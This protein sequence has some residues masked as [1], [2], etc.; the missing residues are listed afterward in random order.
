M[1]FVSFPSRMSCKGSH[2]IGR[3]TVPRDFL[4]E[5][6][7]GRWE[8]GGGGGVEVQCSAV[9]KISLIADVGNG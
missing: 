4:W 6:G 1:G 5:V 7:G 3:Y 8:V 9:L 2:S